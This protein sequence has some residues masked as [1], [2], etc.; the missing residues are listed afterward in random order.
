MHDLGERGSDGLSNQPTIAHT[1]PA[2]R[3][4]LRRMKRHK[5]SPDA[6][7]SLAQGASSASCVLF[8]CDMRASSLKMKS[9]SG[10]LK[11]W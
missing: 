6:G 4:Y 9:L 7:A 3:A 8:I 5:S 11:N 10:W 1:P 2:A